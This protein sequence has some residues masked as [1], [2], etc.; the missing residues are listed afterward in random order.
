MTYYGVVLTIDKGRDEIITLC[1]DE[2]QAV[3]YA[4]LV[5]A[6]V[7]LALAA[8]PCLHLDFS[9]QVMP[10]PVYVQAL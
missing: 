7:V 4:D 1:R 8:T 9:V 10:M 2:E 5:R 3:L 6:G